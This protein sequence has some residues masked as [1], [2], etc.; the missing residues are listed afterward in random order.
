MRFRN[1]RGR[2]IINLALLALAYLAL[3][4]SAGCIVNKLAFHPE[5]LDAS[6][7][8]TLGEEIYFDGG[9]GVGRLHGVLLAAPEPRG[10]VVYMHGNGECVSSWQWNACEIREKFNTTVFVWD[11]P[12]YGKSEGRPTPKNVLAAGRAAVAV[13]AELTV[14][15]PSEII[16]IG[17]SLGASVAADA[18]LHANARALVL[19]SGFVSLKAMCSRVFPILPWAWI[20]PEPMEVEGKIAKFQG[21]VF[22]AHGTADTVVPFKF[23]ERLHAAA[24]EPKAFFRADGKDHNDT[25]P[26]SYWRELERFLWPEDEL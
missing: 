13:A 1:S 22:V 14:T 18:A 16:V 8:T 12:G 17:K 4:G 9:E 10:V 11:Y 24:P 3:A 26:P 6:W 7:S 23:G 19:E 21:A 2:I 5:K 25:W 20:L 15:P